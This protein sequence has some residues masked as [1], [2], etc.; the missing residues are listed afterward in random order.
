MRN[1]QSRASISPLSLNI[2]M[3]RAYKTDLKVALYVKSRFDDIFA[4]DKAAGTHHID[5]G[6]LVTNTKFTSEAIAYA[7]CAGVELLGWGY[8]AEDTL[9]IRMSRAKVYP[10]T[11]LT[12]LSHAEKRLLVEQGT[13]AVDEIVRDRHALD[14]CHL[15]PEQFGIILAEAE[16]LLTL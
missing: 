9:F 7:Q 13:I 8:P 1:I 14:V 5:R 16:G 12:G 6:L 10:I 15:S 4:S 11:A 3:I 2:T